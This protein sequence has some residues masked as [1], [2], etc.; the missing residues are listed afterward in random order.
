[1]EDE[2]MTHKKTFVT[3]IRIH[4]L[5]DENAALKAE[6]SDKR[7]ELQNATTDLGN[8]L[9]RAEKAEARADA[10]ERHLAHIHG[11][12]E[13]F[14]C[15]ECGIQIAK[16]AEASQEQWEREAR[17]EK[18]LREKAEARIAELEARLKPYEN[19]HY[20]GKKEAP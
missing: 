18:S 11:N 13:L 4:T 1:M 20:S 19:S 14:S 16:K 17:Y 8:I 12:P 3:T 6:L 7:L 9:T 2:R 5:E 10:Y 15:G